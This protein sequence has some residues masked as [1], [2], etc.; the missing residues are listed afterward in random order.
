[1]EYGPA[2][3]SDYDAL[4]DI[5]RA[6]GWGVERIREGEAWVARDD[7]AVVLGC[8]RLL[9]S[10]PTGVYVADVLVREDVRGAGIGSELMRAAM[11]TRKG[12]FFLVCHPER[13]AFYERLGFASGGKEAWP[14]GIVEAAM[15][16]EDWDSDH[17]HLHHHMSTTAPA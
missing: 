11:A 14:P 1:M 9:D 15:A 13:K 3:D 6:H 8:C 2:A 4:A 12:P 17:D 10:P 5:Q 16:E 7:D